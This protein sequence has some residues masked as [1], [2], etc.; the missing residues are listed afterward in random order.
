MITKKFNIFSLNTSEI[1]SLYLN[2]T[3]FIW[4][5]WLFVSLVGMTTFEI[6]AKVHIGKLEQK[7]LFFS[8]KVLYLLY[9]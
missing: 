1:L 5:K 3:L 9:C 8:V 6:V 4:R 2:F 7:I